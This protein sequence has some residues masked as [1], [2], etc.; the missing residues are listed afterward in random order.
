M[1]EAGS[2]IRS[3][4]GRLA[5]RNFHSFVINEIGV[6]IVSGRFPVGSILPNDAA[7]MSEYGVSRTVLREALK[8]LEAKGLV[9]AR[10]KVGTRV[11][12]KSRWNLFDPQVL[13]WHYEARPG[14]AFLESLFDTRQTLELRVAHLAATRRSSDHIR[15]LK[16]WAHQME[17]SLDA[18]EPFALAEL[19]LHR[20]LA[21]ASE[22]PFLR[23]IGGIVELAITFTLDAPDEAEGRAR[24]T[25]A[26]SRHTA[27]VS[28]IEATDAAGAGTVMAEIIAA[29]CA[30]VLPA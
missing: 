17:L 23:S 29:D 5:A 28:A 11:S 18:P 16:Y 7:M 19:E 3:L 14:R 9:E 1:S 13:S 21:E 15:M 22:N 2:L 24:R 30:C 27:L 4:S 20:V 26:A 6:G 25:V 8:T 12:P 10:P